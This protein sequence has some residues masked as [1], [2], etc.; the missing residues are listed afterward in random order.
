MLFLSLLMLRQQCHGIIAGII[1]T[2]QTPEVSVCQHCSI[3]FL[4]MMWTSFNM[5]VINFNSQ[6][7]KGEGSSTVHMS[8]Q[9]STAVGERVFHISCPVKVTPS[10]RWVGGILHISHPVKVTSSGGGGILHI[11]PTKLNAPQQ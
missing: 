1:S 10:G 5:S 2:S 7:P 6:L 4:F 9:L 8:L 3:K 11:S